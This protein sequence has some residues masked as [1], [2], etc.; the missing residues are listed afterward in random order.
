MCIRDS[1]CTILFP[2]ILE[3]TAISAG[4]LSVANFGKGPVL[5]LIGFNFFLQFKD[6]LLPLVSTKKPIF[7]NA[8]SSEFKNLGSILLT[9]TFPLDIAP[10]HK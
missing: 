7:F 9:V 6:I 2:G 3:R 1:S 10:T 5:K 8:I 4:I